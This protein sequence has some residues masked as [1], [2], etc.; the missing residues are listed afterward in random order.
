VRWNARNRTDGSVQK[1]ALRANL[2]MS[3]SGSTIIAQPKLG[4]LSSGVGRNAWSAFPHHFF[5]HTVHTKVYTNTIDAS[6]PDK[7]AKTE[8]PRSGVR[9]K[10]KTSRDR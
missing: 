4:S 9:E 8:H 2:V 6:P 5:L 3:G 1:T 10:K 7:A